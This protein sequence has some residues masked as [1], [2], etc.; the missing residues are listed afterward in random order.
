VRGDHDQQIAFVKFVEEA[1]ANLGQRAASCQ[2]GANALGDK[3][4]ARTEAVGH[5]RGFDKPTSAAKLG[6][7]VPRRRVRATCGRQPLARFAA[8]RGFLVSSSQPGNRGASGD[9]SGFAGAVV[10][11]AR[12]G[13]HG[14]EL[15]TMEPWNLP[16]MGRAEF[17]MKQAPKPP[18]STIRHIQ[19]PK[20]RLELAAGCF[21]GVELVLG[22]C[23]QLQTFPNAN[24][25]AQTPCSTRE[26]GI[27]PWGMQ[28]WIWPGER[29]RT[30]K[31]RPGQNQRN[32]QR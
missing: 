26:D 4:D 18:S 15:P 29:Q 14:G 31:G 28:F 30:R 25:H 7:C 24:V 2:R 20:H 12:G 22:I 11:R 21:S 16:K 13:C 27:M 5:R 9:W 32:A 1:D 19:S 3:A 17:M 6:R 23:V 8:R 10:Q